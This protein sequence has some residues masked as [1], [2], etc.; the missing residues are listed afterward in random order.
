MFFYVDGQC[1]WIID[2]H[3]IAPSGVINVG[4]ILRVCYVFNAEV[5][6][7]RFFILALPACVEVYSFVAVYFVVK[8]RRRVKGDFV[9]DD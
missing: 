6:C 5:N 2:L 7:P 9:V 8:R 1:G 3:V 4:K